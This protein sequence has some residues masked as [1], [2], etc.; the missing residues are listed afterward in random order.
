LYEV[1]TESEVCRI[2]EVILQTIKVVARTPSRISE[3]V[4]RNQILTKLDWT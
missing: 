2:Y 4:A 3:L 1:V